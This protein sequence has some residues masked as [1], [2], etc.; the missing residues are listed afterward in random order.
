[1]IFEKSKPRS[2]RKYHRRKA[3]RQEAGRRMRDD[4]A[5]FEMYMTLTYKSR[6]W[7]RGHAFW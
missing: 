5:M 3:A 2:R 4:P 7:W 1:M 6:R